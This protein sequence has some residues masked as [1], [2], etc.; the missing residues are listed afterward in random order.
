M[1]NKDFRQQPTTCKL[2]II[3]TSLFVISLNFNLHFNYIFTCVFGTGLLIYF[4]FNRKYYKPN[5]LH[6]LLFVYTAINALSLLWTSDLKS[7]FYWLKLQMAFIYFPLAFCLFRLDKKQFDIIL[8]SIFRWM[9][10][11]AVLSVCSWILQ[12]RAL[13][14]PLSEAFIMSKHMFV[15]IYQPFDVVFAWSNFYH[16]TYISVTLMLGLS[17]GWYYALKNNV[18]G[19]ELAFYTLIVLL[20]AILTQ[21]RFM[22]VAWLLVNILFVVYMLKTKPKLQW[23]VIVI[24]TL[25]AAF[26]LAFYPNKIKN[27]FSDTVR[28]AHYKAAFEAIEDN[29]FLGTGLGGMTKYINSDNIVYQHIKDAQIISIMGDTPRNEEDMSIL[30]KQVNIDFIGLNP[31]NQLIGDFMQTGI[32]GFLSILSIIIYVSYLC[33]R[34]KNQLL[35]CF[36]SVFFL[37]MIIEM[38]LM[39]ENGI[40]CF[41]FMLCLLNQYNP[42]WERDTKH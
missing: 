35:F 15:G 42:I 4:I 26:A 41:A 27:F 21:S 22:I 17:I 16:P 7:G 2:L 13:E 34:Q 11:F 33:I 32:L 36:F 38:P 19:Y 6:I 23:V 8:I 30:R 9:I 37:L 18:K 5:T 10:L 39:V 31:H 40:M 20:I 14:I 24:I 29:P 1:S 3:S 12:S 25:I 28:I